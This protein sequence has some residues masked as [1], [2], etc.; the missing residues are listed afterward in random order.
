MQRVLRI[1]TGPGAK[2]VNWCD[3]AEVVKSVQK[4]PF[5]R[6][7]PGCTEDTPGSSPCSEYLSG[8]TT[9]FLEEERMLRSPQQLSDCVSC[10]AM[11]PTCRPRRNTPR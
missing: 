5:W 11:P 4:C 7:T 10:D 2:V 9:E 6:G 8:R 3:C 1:I